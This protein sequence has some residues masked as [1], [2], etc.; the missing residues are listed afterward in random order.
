MAHQMEQRSGV[1]V[2]APGSHYQ[3]LQGRHAH[4]RIDASPVIHGAYGG[5]AAQMTGDDLEIADGNF[6]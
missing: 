1:H 5:P 6:Q 4:A 2:P 3:T